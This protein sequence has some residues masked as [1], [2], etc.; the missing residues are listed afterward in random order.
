MKKKNLMARKFEWM[1][2]F[3]IE[4]EEISR[5]FK[6]NPFKTFLDSLLVRSFV[7]SSNALWPHWSYIF[8]SPRCFFLQFNEIVIFSHLKRIICT[9]ELCNML[10]VVF[11]QKLKTI[12]SPKRWSDWKT[13]PR[14][15]N[16]RAFSPDYEIYMRSMGCAVQYWGIT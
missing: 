15:R 8:L 2:Q 3:G 10:I 14:S 16:A 12:I 11:V 13:M 4:F 1:E 5:N 6:R 7:S 9:L